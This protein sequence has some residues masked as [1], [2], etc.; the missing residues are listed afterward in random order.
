MKKTALSV[1][2]LAGLGFGAVSAASA[3]DVYP[4]DLFEQ[5]DKVENQYKDLVSSVADEHEW[6]AEGGTEVPVSTIKL[7]GTKYNVI[8][9][10][11]PHSCA[12]QKLVTLIDAKGGDSTG[13]LVDNSGDTGSGGPTQSEITWLGEPGQGM[14]SYMAA[15]LF[16]ASSD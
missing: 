9:S 7:N 12:S 11:K 15:Y 14:R 13:A 8:A 4:R 1:L 16:S 5:N 3:A 6:I 10:C 2:A